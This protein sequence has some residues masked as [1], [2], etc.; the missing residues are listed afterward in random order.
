MLDNDQAMAMDT[1]VNRTRFDMNCPS[2]TGQV[3]SREVVQPALR[4]LLHWRAQRREG[5]RMYFKR[6]P[7]GIYDRVSGCDKRKVTSLYA[8][9]AGNGCFA[10][11]SGPFIQIYNSSGPVR[12]NSTQVLNTEDGKDRR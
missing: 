5:A 1:G 7:A 11:G 9:R 10:T 8:L 4:D 3:I 6:H 2:A 12:F